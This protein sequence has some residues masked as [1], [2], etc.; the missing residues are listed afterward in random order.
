MGLG[1]VDT[2]QT[3]TLCHGAWKAA[4]GLG[5]VR[6]IGLVAT[7]RGSCSHAVAPAHRHRTGVAGSAPRPCG[8]AESFGLLKV[9]NPLGTLLITCLFTLAAAPDADILMVKPGLAQWLRQ[10]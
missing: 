4:L 3:G 1:A 5:L 9:V 8:R 2:M 6:V 7:G 10:G